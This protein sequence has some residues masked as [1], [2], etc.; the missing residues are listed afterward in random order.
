M[1]VFSLMIR[2][3]SG[4]REVLLDVLRSVQRHTRVQNGCMD[5]M[6]Y[7]ENNEDNPI[8]LYLERWRSRAALHNH[9]RSSLYMRVLHA[10]DLADKPPEVSFYEVSEERG[11][12]LVQ[13][14]RK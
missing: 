5:C 3:V 6:I 10:M 2:P 4:K 9:I 12:E 13:E 14:L 11:L 8:I 7:E 1:F